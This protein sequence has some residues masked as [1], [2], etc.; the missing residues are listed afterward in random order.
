MPDPHDG[1]GDPAA[2]ARYSEWISEVRRLYVEPKGPAELHVPAELEDDTPEPRARGRGRLLGRRRHQAPEEVV[3][4]VAPSPAH[5]S[6]ADLI[7]AQPS[8]APTEAHSAPAPDPRPYNLEPVPADEV[9]AEVVV[10]DEAPHD[11]VALADDV[12]AEVVVEDESP[13]DEVALADDVSAEVVV[14]DES[15]ADEAP[16]GSS[17]WDD[18]LATDAP[19]ADDDEP[20]AARPAASSVLADDP[21]WTVDTVAEVEAEDD[22][23]F[24]AW[25]AEPVADGEP[26]DDE[27]VFE[28]WPVTVDEAT[29]ATDHEATTPVDDTENRPAPEAPHRRSWWDEGELAEDDEADTAA[30]EMDPEPDADTL[31]TPAAPAAP[32]PPAEDPAPRRGDRHRASGRGSGRS[33][34]R[35]GRSAAPAPAEDPAPHVSG[36]PAETF[37]A[38]LLAA[39]AEQ[40]DGAQQADV[41]E[42]PERAQGHDAPLS[43]AETRA[44]ARRAERA[45][46]ARRRRALVAAIVLLVVV[47]A[48][49]WVLRP[50]ATASADTTTAQHA[51]AVLLHSPHGGGPLLG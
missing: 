1:G 43:R 16:S 35:T 33:S 9:L 50:H 41:P 22:P 2:D 37:A 26:V 27:P 8:A 36:T 4:P 38:A 45:R 17:W 14:E 11:E 46:T 25:P 18:A 7:N 20:E 51:A 31:A 34:R 13:V 44:A 29:A 48:A 3:A 47:A 19:T 30:A 40:G 6:L 5:P 10:E 15:P 39:E 32:E 28:A 23:G 12:S 24:R 42:R 21:S 49:W